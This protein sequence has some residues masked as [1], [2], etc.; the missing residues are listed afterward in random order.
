MTPKHKTQDIVV[1]SDKFA[2][3]FKVMKLK[4]V[5]VGGLE[6]FQPVALNLFILFRQKCDPELLH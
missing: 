3:E 6:T 2:E 4:K 5:Q 1:N